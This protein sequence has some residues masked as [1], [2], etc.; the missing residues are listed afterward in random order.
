MNELAKWAWLILIPLLAFGYWALL[1]YGVG[2]VILLLIIWLRP[3]WLDDDKQSRLESKKRRIENALEKRYRK[4]IRKNKCPDNCTLIERIVN[5]EKIVNLYWI[6]EEEKPGPF[7]YESKALHVDFK[8]SPDMNSVILYIISK[9][10]D[11]RAIKWVQS[12]IN[13]FSL[14]VDGL[15]DSVLEEDV[16]EYK[17]EVCRTIRT[18]N[19]E[20]MK[21]I[22]RRLFD[23]GMNIKINIIYTDNVADNIILKL[24]VKHI[25]DRFQYI[26]TQEKHYIGEESLP[27]FTKE[28]WMTYITKNNVH[29]GK[30]NAFVVSNINKGV[31]NLINVIDVP[32]GTP[33]L[34]KRSRKLSAKII[35]ETPNFYYTNQLSV[36]GDSNKKNIYVLS[37]KSRGIGFYKWE[38]EQLV[39]GEVY[40]PV[41]TEN[42]NGFIAID[43]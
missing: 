1:L 20:D 27:Q 23:N 3:E 35:V 36:S 40:L 13:G 37:N 31:A 42:P 4:Q 21:V 25:F 6:S 41:K 22:K 10:K 33:V 2:I 26:D 30:D 43:I 11:I 32:K 5:G 17:K 7:S 28:Q 16:I 8:L 39:E 29:F 24:K 15:T 12:E 14:T 9:S 19:P 18:S 34:L 38:G